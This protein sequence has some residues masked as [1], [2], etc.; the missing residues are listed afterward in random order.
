MTT[1]MTD[2][3]S[4]EKPR[5]GE[6]KVTLMLLLVSSSLACLGS[7]LPVSEIA[8]DMVSVS[9]E[10]DSDG[11]TTEGENPDGDVG[12]LLGD[13]TILPDLVDSSVG[14][15]S[16]GDIV[17]TVDERSS[18]SSH[19]L[20]ESVQELGLVVVVAGAGVDLIDIARDDGL[21]L[22][23]GNNVDIDTT[24]ESKLDGPE[25]ELGVEDGD[26]GLGANQRLPG[27]LLVGEGVSVGAGGVS[28]LSLGLGGG[29][30][31]LSVGSALGVGTGTLGLELL[32]GKVT[33][34][35]VLD[36]ALVVGRGGR[37]LAAAEEE[38]A[39]EDVV[40]LELPVLLDDQAVDPGDEESGNEQTESSTSGN[41]DT[42][43][44]S[45]GEV[46]LV[47]TTLP[48]EQHSNQGAGEPGEDGESNETLH[49]GVGSEENG[50]FRD[51]EEDGTS[52]TRENGGDDPG[53]EDL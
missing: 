17:G 15:D 24:E 50:I 10:T 4:M 35:E 32:G 29:V 19:N 7:F 1:A 34:V 13:N 47:V 21:G 53:K 11:N 8:H 51:G 14:T 28:E 38:R 46:D 25:D 43:E 44:L 18:A 41:D 27:G 52:N 9:P 45:L 37:D 31:S 36:G 2:P 42:G 48:D 3:S 6:I 33:L 12:L 30:A 5:E 16:V 40:P 39:H 23:R 22:L 26:I 49:D 20:E